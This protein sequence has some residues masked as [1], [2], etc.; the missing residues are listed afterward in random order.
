MNFS[1]TSFQ[2]AKPIWASGKR[3]EMNCALRLETTISKASNLILRMAGHTSYQVYI[4]DNFVFFGP[5]RAGRG[6]YRVDEVPIDSYLTEGKN[7]ITVFA[8][9][10]NCDSYYQLNEPSFFCAEFTDG[11]NTFSETGSDA[12]QIYLRHDKIQKVQ[13]Y[14]TQ[15]PFAEV[16]DLTKLPQIT[17]CLAEIC[18]TV[19]WISRELSLPAFEKEYFS[20][21]ISNGS[22]EFCEP[23][24]YHTCAAL[25]RPGNTISGF[26]LDELDLVSVHEVQ[27]IRLLPQSTAVE[28]GAFFL[29]NDTYVTASMVGNRTGLISLD[30]TCLTDTTLILFFD[31]ILIDDKIHLLRTNCANVVIYRLKGGERYSLITAEPYTF[32]YMTLV[33]IGGKIVL[34]SGGVIRT[35]FN[36]AEIIKKL[37]PQKSDA[38]IQRIYKAAVETFRQNTFDIF[39]DC[40]SRERGGYLCDS[41]FT[42]RVEYLMTGKSKVERCFLSNFAMED[43]YRDIPN[44]AIPM[45]YPA[46]HPD[47]LFIPN[48]G[49]WYLLELKEY[50]QR[51]NDLQ[52]IMELRSKMEDFA[53]FLRKYE[54]SDGLLEKLSGWIFVEWSAC[55][56]LV[57]DV[58]YPT[59]ML[60]YRFKKTMY[61]LYGDEKYLT[62]AQALRVTI[63]KQSL[64]DLFFCDNSVYDAKGEL[65]LTGEC[66][67]TC[68]YYA[69]FTGVATR[70]EDGALWDT[71][72]N[73]FGPERKHTKKWPNIHFSNAFIGNYLRLELLA[74]EKIHERLE[75]NIRD[76]FDYMAKR[77]GTLW[78]HDKES[79]SCNHGF[80]SHVLVWLDQLGYLC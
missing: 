25:A 69:F 36:A 70:E 32:M 74:K 49:M 29:L 1:E 43:S 48:W 44:G 6:Y 59:N 26:R 68:Q 72:V 18:P 62:E 57:Q 37:N 24:Q 47:G 50:L 33:S 55:N 13:R 15:R 16:Y 56:D 2:K 53:S 22:V 66:T 10:Y 3:Y 14:S 30:V 5:A 63:R 4:N 40:P 61:D 11:K 41:F 71:M 51:S 42:A 73:D 21:F 8:N 65:V 35:D 58:N 12:W 79:A 9:G 52:L 54:N 45:C 19:K 77:N 31:E 38:Q 23:E 27:K 39:M 80:A 78:E 46:E 75:R 20:R 60:Y 76:Y 67:E 64:T 34:H 7:R 17:P 28:K